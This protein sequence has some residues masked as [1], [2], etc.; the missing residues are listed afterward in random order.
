M[1]PLSRFYRLMV[2]IPELENA[3]SLE[4]GEAI[5]GRLLE[6][7]KTMTKGQCRVVTTKRG[8]FTPS[9]N[10]YTNVSV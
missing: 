2:V 9:S 3:H 4:T 10:F 6:T 5:I 1:S 8:V 7:K